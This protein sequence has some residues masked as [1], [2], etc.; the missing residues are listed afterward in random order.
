MSPP[1]DYHNFTGSFDL[2]MFQI[3]SPPNST[4]ACD[5]NANLKVYPLHRPPSRRAG[6]VMPRSG[7]NGGVC[8][9]RQDLAPVQLLCHLRSLRGN[10]S[11]LII[12]TRKQLPC[13][14][15]LPL[16]FPPKVFIR[17]LPRCLGC[18]S[19]CQGREESAAA[20]GNL[21]LYRGCPRVITPRR[22]SS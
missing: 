3:L 18:H 20:R 12:C 2:G 22:A 15:L 8:C 10:L 5:T 4:D 19:A 21:T 11:A 14:L 7:C 9:W 13:Q 17:L 6:R 16:L 1:A